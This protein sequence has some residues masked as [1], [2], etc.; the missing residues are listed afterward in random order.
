MEKKLYKKPKV[1]LISEFE[2]D[3]L[4]AS[5][6]IVWQDDELLYDDMF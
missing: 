1:N 4:S 3:I 2:M 6:G 5:G